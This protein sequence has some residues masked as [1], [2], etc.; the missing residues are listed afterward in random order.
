MQEA[1]PSSDWLDKGQAGR[2]V[3]LGPTIPAMQV[4]EE[5]DMTGQEG[6]G[7]TNGDYEL[8]NGSKQRQ[9][10]ASLPKPDKQEARKDL[11]PTQ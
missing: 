1:K 10:S 7:S 5:F 6:K 4:N 8:Q 2:S 3:L 11:T 9:S